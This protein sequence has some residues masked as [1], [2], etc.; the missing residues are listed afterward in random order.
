MNAL[1]RTPEGRQ[2]ILDA[3]RHP[4]AFDASREPLRALRDLVV[5]AEALGFD[6]AWTPATSGA[7]LTRA[8]EGLARLRYLFGDERPAEAAAYGPLRE[9]GDLITAL[10]HAVAEIHNPGTARAAGL[11]LLGMIDAALKPQFGEAF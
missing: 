9:P 7:I 10:R 3:K 4:D 5:A 6:G 2:F 11:D 8:Q 1:H